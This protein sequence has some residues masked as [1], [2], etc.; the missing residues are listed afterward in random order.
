MRC[1]N[2]NDGPNRGLADK[3]LPLKL[4]PAEVLNIRNHL[5]SIDLNIINALLNIKQIVKGKIYLE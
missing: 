5:N 3:L 4:P 2:L 1:N